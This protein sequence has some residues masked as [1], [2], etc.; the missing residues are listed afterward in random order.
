MRAYESLI[1]VIHTL[2]EYAR[3]CSS[4]KSPSLLDVSIY[5][6]APAPAV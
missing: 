6:D 3:Y 2:Y 5:R 4:R 1:R